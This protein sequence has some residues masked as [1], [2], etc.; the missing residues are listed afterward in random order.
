[1][2][3]EYGKENM[4][5]PQNGIPYRDTFLFLII[6]IVLIHCDYLFIYA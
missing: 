1:M 4:L 3:K 2:E 5:S 6:Q